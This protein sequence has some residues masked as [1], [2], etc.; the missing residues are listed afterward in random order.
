[1]VFITLQGTLENNISLRGSFAD[2]IDEDCLKEM[3]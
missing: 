3:S 1:M 2:M